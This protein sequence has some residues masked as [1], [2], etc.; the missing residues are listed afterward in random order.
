VLVDIIR[1][2]EL[3][4]CWNEFNLN[5][6]VDRRVVLLI[7]AVVFRPPVTIANDGE[8]VGFDDIWNLENPDLFEQF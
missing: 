2:G 3:N 5:T 7:V 8:I 1:I 4:A 6:A